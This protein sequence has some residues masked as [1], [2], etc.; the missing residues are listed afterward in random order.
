MRCSVFSPIAKVAEG[1][2]GGGARPSGGGGAYS[3][4]VWGG[5][6]R[7]AGLSGPKRPSG[8]AGCWA[9]WAGS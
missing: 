8:P 9:D 1:G 7:P 4:S 2:H 5:R 3:V 6:S